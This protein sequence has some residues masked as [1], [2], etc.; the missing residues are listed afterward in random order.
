MVIVGVVLRPD[1]WSIK[2]FIFVGVPL[3]Y[4]SAGAQTSKVV[5]QFS[6]N[7]DKIIKV[8]LEQDGKLK[9]P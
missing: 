5:L 9:Y 2:I 4:M 7:N 8:E 1:C 3:L 6:S